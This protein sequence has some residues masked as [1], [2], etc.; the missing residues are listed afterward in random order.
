MHLIDNPRQN[1]DKF[2]F[3]KSWKGQGGVKFNAITGSNLDANQQSIIGDNQLVGI[4]V[5]INIMSSKF[6]LWRT[7]G[8]NVYK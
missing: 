1:L 4:F 2:S 5:G 6:N 7:H 3:S 8:A